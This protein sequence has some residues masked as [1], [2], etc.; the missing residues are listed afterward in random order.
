VSGKTYEFRDQLKSVGAKWNAE[1]KVW[2][3]PKDADIEFLTPKPP[4]K[5]IY[6]KPIPKFGQCC[7]K[8]KLEYEREQGPLVYVC[9]L[10]GRRYTTEMG[11]YT[12][13]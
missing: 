6:K 11:A 8:A 4:P 1:L 7:K 12:G 13:D 2:S 10:H 5:I 3:V 9:P